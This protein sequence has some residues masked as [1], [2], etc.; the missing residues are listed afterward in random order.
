MKLKAWPPTTKGMAGK[1]TRVPMMPPL[2]RIVA[3]DILSPVIAGLR[4]RV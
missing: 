4:L 3:E 1:A 2:V